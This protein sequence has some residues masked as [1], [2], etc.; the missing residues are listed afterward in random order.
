MPRKRTTF[1]AAFKA[2]VALAAHKGD[3]TVNELASQFGIHANLIYAWKRQLTDTVA[4]LFEGPA[5]KKKIPDG[6]LDPAE[7]FEQI[8]RLKMELEWLK[9]KADQ[10]G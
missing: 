2:K 3:K 5:S 7:L 1:T 10:L 4:D 6:Q 9:K 8:G